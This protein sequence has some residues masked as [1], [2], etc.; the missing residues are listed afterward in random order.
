MSPID[1]AVSIAT[2]THGN[3]FVGLLARIC[4]GRIQPSEGAFPGAVCA[5]GSDMC[6]PGS[7]CSE[8]MAQ[9]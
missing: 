5:D 8:D 2:S 3:R 7:D 4:S 9:P 6:G 1:K